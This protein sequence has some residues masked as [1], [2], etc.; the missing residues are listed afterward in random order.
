VPSGLKS[1]AGIK[2]GRRAATASFKLTPMDQVPYPASSR[3]RLDGCS[4]PELVG[5]LTTKGQ[6]CGAGAQDFRCAE[7]MQGPASPAADC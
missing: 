2:A 1:S 7:S 6:G 4:G 3:R 5:R